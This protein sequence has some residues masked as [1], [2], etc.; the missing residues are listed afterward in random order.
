MA[1]LGESWG[2]FLMASKGNLRNSLVESWGIPWG[3]RSEKSGGFLREF[4]GNSLRDSCG[5]QLGHLSGDS[6]EGNHLVESWG[7]PGRVSVET[8]GNL[9]NPLG[10]L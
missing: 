10:N 5:N 6:L 2:N 3:N 1:E 7:N 9:W 8:C 4:G